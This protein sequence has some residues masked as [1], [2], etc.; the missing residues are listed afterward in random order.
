MRLSK[1]AVNSALLISEKIC[2]IGFAFVV[3]ILLARIGGPKLFGQYAYITSFASLFSPLC[4]MGLNNIVTKY[5]VKY[6]HNSHYYVKSALTIRLAG[7]ISSLI[8]GMIIV[9]L[10]NQAVELSINILLLLTFQTFN[11]LLVYEYFFLARKQ[12]LPTLAVRI[13]VVVVANT[14]KVITILYSQNLLLLVLIQGLEYALVGISYHVIYRKNLYNKII[15]RPLGKHASLIMFHKGKWLLLSGVAAIIYMKIDQVMLANMISEEE[16]AFY[17]AAAKLSEFWYAFPILIANAYTAQLIEQRR[18]GVALFNNLITNLLSKLIA[19][20]ILVSV[21]TYFLSNVIIDLVY[22]EQYQAS[23]PILSI[24]I[25]ASIFVFQR[26][27]FSKWIIINNVLKYSLFTTGLGALINVILN[28]VLIPKLGGIGAAWATLFS[29][30]TA[31]YF[32]LFLAKST[33]PFAKLM[34]LSFTHLFK[35]PTKRVK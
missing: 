19:A 21:T 35:I 3:S 20:A 33:L 17:A 2:V 27:I 23:A 34:T 29:Y 24:H 25:F 11:F 7:A 26:A 4:V 16:V 30:A 15:T 18:Q 9:V 5:V 10:M 12:V 8:L 1:S 31:N 14:I 32:G 22:G 13:T 6:P 28:I